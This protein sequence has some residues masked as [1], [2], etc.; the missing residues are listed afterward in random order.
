[1]LEFIRRKQMI[2]FLLTGIKKKIGAGPCRIIFSFLCIKQLLPLHHFIAP[3]YKTICGRGA[4]KQS[5]E[6]VDIDLQNKMFVFKKVNYCQ[7][8]GTYL[9][10]N[11]YL[12]RFES[13]SNFSVSKKLNIM[14]YEIINICNSRF[15]EKYSPGSMVPDFPLK[16]QDYIVKNWY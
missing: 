12:Y 15:I 11:P 10:Y 3:V 8:P 9:V 14:V 5:R 6:I 4:H 13:H 7:Y 1:M 2:Y 16:L